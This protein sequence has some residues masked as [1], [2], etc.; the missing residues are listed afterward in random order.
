MKQPQCLRSWL[1][2][3]LSRALPALLRSLRL[4]LVGAC[5][6][7]AVVRRTLYAAHAAV[8]CAGLEF[9]FLSKITGDE[10]CSRHRCCSHSL[11]LTSVTVPA[12]RVP[13]GGRPVATQ[14]LSVGGLGR[15]YAAAARRA[16]D[17]LWSRRSAID[18]VGSHIDI[19]SGLWTQ[20]QATLGTNV[21]SFFEYLLKSHLLFGDK[22]PPP[23]TRPPTRF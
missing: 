7:S 9:V 19:N 3:P 11:E 12:G 8:G 16:V 14:A 5:S 10:R 22:Y 20:Q 4:A 15:R 21:D 2:F 6:Q 23:P 17:A 1:G 13:V 18:L